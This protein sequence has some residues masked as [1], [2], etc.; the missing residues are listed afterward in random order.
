[1]RLGLGYGQGWFAWRLTANVRIT[2]NE[3]IYTMRNIC[4]GGRH[5]GL[6]LGLGFGLGLE[7]GLGLGLW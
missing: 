3:P 2:K 5:M 4:R 7:L 1:M 6:G